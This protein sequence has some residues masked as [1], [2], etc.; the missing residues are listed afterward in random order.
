MRRGGYQE[1]NILQRRIGAVW[2]VGK[3]VL[4]AIVASL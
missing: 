4:S 3:A 1:C 2:R